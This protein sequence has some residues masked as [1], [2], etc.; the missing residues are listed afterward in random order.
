MVSKRLWKYI[1]ILEPAGSRPMRIRL[2]MQKKLDIIIA[3]GK[4]ADKSEKEKDS[5]Y[6]QLEEMIKNTLKKN[7]L[8]IA[9]D[10]NAKVGAAVSDAE[11]GVIGKVAVSDEQERVH[12]KRSD[13]QQGQANQHLRVARTETVQHKF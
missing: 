9:G 2:K 7:S 11:R 8:M 3:Y 6:K 1:D 10:L 13:R 4:Q 12:G 5:F